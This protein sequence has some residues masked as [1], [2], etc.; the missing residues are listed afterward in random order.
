MESIK[1]SSKGQMIIPKAIREALGIRSGTDL[2][3]E[4]D[5]DTGFRV[6]VAPT[7]R[8]ASVQRLA[9]S[10]AHRAKPMTRKREAA[11]LLAMART[12]DERTKPNGRQR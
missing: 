8:I 9:G 6:T 7:D 2:N 10:L 12:D 11:A 4:L 3:V 1:A 5:S